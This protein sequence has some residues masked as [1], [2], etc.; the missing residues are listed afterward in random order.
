MKEDDDINYHESHGNHDLHVDIQ[1]SDSKQKLYFFTNT[2]KE[3]TENFTPFLKKLKSMKKNVKII[4]CNNA[5]KNKTLE[6]YFTRKFDGFGL[7][8]T[9]PGNTQKTLCRMVIC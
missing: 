6:E 8:F 1:D 5:G 9:S 4:F 2:R 7:E 3:M